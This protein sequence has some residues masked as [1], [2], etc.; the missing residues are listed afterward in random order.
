M[1]GKSRLSSSLMQESTL[2]KDSHVGDSREMLQLRACGTWSFFPAQVVLWQH[3]VKAW[4]WLWMPQSPLF[5]SPN[6]TQ[7]LAKRPA[8]ASDV[9]ISR[10]TGAFDPVRFQSQPAFVCWLWPVLLTQLPCTWSFSAS[11]RAT[12]FV[13]YRAVFWSAEV[14]CSYSCLHLGVLERSR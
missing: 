2:H 10:S 14:P 3:C 11:N 1:L 7:T 12:P 4:P 13:Q 8:A 9:P 5:Q 6:S